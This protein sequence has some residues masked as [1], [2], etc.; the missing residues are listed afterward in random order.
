M[1][2]SLLWPCWLGVKAL[3]RCL[4]V[5]LWANVLRTDMRPGTCYLDVRDDTRSHASRGR[6]VCDRAL[7][8]NLTVKQCCCTIGLG[9]NAIDDQRRRQ[10][11]VACPVF[12]SR[13]Q[14]TSTS[15]R[16]SSYTFH[17]SR[18]RREMYIGHA[19]LCVCL[20]VCVCMSLA[21]FPHY[22]TD[23][24]VSCGNGGGAL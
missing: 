17:V 3:S 16:S 5:C 13:T 6:I 11:C 8:S 1:R 10:P 9:W 14:P 18:R 2:L 19:R 22:C 24:D 21:A 12:G 23:P 20:S 4:Y 7:S 15:S